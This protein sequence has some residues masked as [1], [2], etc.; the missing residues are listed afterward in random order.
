MKLPEHEFSSSGY[1]CC[2]FADAPPAA[3]AQVASAD[4]SADASSM[5]PA[6][7]AVADGA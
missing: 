5:L 2:N 6:E 4:A 3:G 1:S 7:A